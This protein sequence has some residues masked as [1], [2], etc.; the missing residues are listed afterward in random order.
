M[1][2]MGF[3][4]K[5]QSKHVVRMQSKHAGCM[6][7]FIVMCLDWFSLPWEY[8]VHAMSDSVIPA[9]LAANLKK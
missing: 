6:G 5:M 7:F 2:C 8:L 4:D 9:D 1:Q 3:F